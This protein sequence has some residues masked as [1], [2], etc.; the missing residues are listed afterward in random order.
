MEKVKER[1]TNFVKELIN[2]NKEFIIFGVVI[3][4]KSE[5]IKEIKEGELISEYGKRLQINTIRLKE[6][7]GHKE[8]N[9]IIV[10]EFL[11]QIKNN[12]EEFLEEK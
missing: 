9:L 8:R 2:D 5:I 11:S 1:Y 6:F 4:S 12:L 3:D 10:K 7:K